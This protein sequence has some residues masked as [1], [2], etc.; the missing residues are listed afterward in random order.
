VKSDTA[1][2]SGNFGFI[3]HARTVPAEDKPQLPNS[4]DPS[5]SPKP[6]ASPK[7]S[8]SVSV[9]DNGSKITTETVI[10]IVVLLVALVVVAFVLLLIYTR[11]RDAV[12]H[13]VRHSTT[14]SDGY[15]NGTAAGGIHSSKHS[16]APIAGR[17]RRANPRGA[18]E[19]VQ[20]DGKHP[21]ELGGAYGDEVLEGRLIRAGPSTQSGNSEDNAAALQRSL[22]NDAPVGAVRKQSGIFG[23]AGGGGGG[24]TLAV[25]G[26]ALLGSGRGSAAA[27]GSGMLS[28]SFARRS[29]IAEDTEGGATSSATAFEIDPS[30][31]TLGAELGRG[32]FGSVY[33]GTYAGTDVA[34][35][36]VRCNT[37]G[38]ITA[39]ENEVLIM[40]NVRHPNVL[41]LVAYTCGSDNQFGIVMERM[42]TTLYH[43]SLERVMPIFE[44]VDI[45]LGIARGLAYLHSRRIIHRDLK[46]LNVLMTA[47][48]QPKIADF[49]LSKAMASAS[50]M[51]SM[52]GTVS[53]MAPE[54]LEMKPYRASADVYSFAMVLY[55]MIAGKAPFQGF[56]TPVQV[57]WQVIR[58]GLRPE[59]PERCPP[60]LAD[61]MTRSW[62]S[63]PDARPTFRELIEELQ[64]L[65]DEL[66]A[67]AKV[68]SA[69]AGA[70]DGG[71]PIKRNRSLPEM[72]KD[73]SPPPNGDAAGQQG[74][75]PA[76]AGD[77]ADGTGAKL[78]LLKSAPPAV[79]QAAA[80]RAADP[81]AAVPPAENIRASPDL[82][83]AAIDLQLE[84][85][86]DSE[87]T[88]PAP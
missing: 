71:E 81:A 63:D 51:K 48:G 44:V 21:T 18:V 33:A 77:P 66:A 5:S 35:K 41:L 73:A 13:E 60:K 74:A 34:I 3:L 86:T 82:S 14:S 55:Q 62:G 11:R 38:E 25:P 12:D 49:G 16:G 47:S 22:G 23:S 68:Q 46:A 54:V 53:H 37:D 64:A 30:E 31:L 19:V 8:P 36:I 84:P 72:P 45:A 67:E 43:Y 24:G 78:P 83:R 61:I 88:Q 57:A 27:N 1:I 26:T 17:A 58:E 87:R 2:P 20:D 52:V 76:A 75:A 50:Q 70:E 40:C 39:L 32:A 80:E 59:V 79:N 7:D 65:R 10:I 56:D 29:G 4:A 42:H 6:S 9:S 85:M 69:T 28:G 15:G